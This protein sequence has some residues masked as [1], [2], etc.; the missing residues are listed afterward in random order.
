MQD[1]Y[2]LF[3]AVIEAGSLSAAARILKLSPGMVSKRLAGLEQRLGARLIQR[4]TRRLS[5][6]DVGQAFH[7]QVVA[8]L[9]A[10]ERAE[11][12]VAGR[13]GTPSGRLRV[14]VPT[15]FGRMHIAPWLKDFVDAYP[16]IKLDIDLT[17]HFVDLLAE[18]VDVAI[19]IG[20]PPDNSLA[21]HRLAPNHR[22]LCASPGYVQVHGE[23]QSPAEL[24]RHGLLAATGQLPW[25]LMGPRGPLIIQ[26]ESLVRTNSS[27]VV[28]ELVLAGAGIALRSSWDIAEQLRAGSLVRILPDLEGTPDVGIY[29]VRP[30]ADLVSPNVQAFI[31]FLDRLLAPMPPW[32]RNPD[33][34]GPDQ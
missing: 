16:A 10:V 28:R 30:R 21:A 27:E 2:A 1:D 13:A 32:D 8:I 11:A 9:T 5:L 19:R 33:V 6:T 26:G 17:D 34:S 3:A 24:D 7:E 12:M 31:A 25:R 4:T 20:P 14:S 18:R 23:P 29:A 15:S 22:L